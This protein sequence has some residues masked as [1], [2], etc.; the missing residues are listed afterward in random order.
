M[1]NH[2]LFMI[3]GQWSAVQRGNQTGLSLLKNKIA[4]N[5]LI[6]SQMSIAA[7]GFP[8]EPS[9]LLRVGG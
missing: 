2:H 9:R 4:A 1:L 6:N 5:P 8:S 7:A 3:L